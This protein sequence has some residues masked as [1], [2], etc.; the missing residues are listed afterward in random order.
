VGLQNFGGWGSLITPPH[1][2]RYATGHKKMAN[3]RK[4]IGILWSRNAHYLMTQK[5][6]LFSEEHS[7]FKKGKSVPLQD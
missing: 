7:A 3:I 6:V 4:V 2:P 1:P 5:I